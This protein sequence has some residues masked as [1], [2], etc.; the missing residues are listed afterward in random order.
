MHCG[1]D[2]MCRGGCSCRWKT[3]NLICKVDKKSGEKKDCKVD[4]STRDYDGCIDYSDQMLT[5]PPDTTRK[6][7]VFSAFL[8]HPR[9]CN[10]RRSI[11]S[12]LY[13]AKHPALHNSAK[14]DKTQQGQH[15]EPSERVFLGESARDPP[16]STDSSRAPRA[17]MV[18]SMQF[19]V[20]EG[21]VR[22][23][24]QIGPRPALGC[25][26][27]SLPV[28]VSD[29]L[30]IGGSDQNRQ[31]HTTVLNRLNRLS[32]TVESVIGPHSLRLRLAGH[33]ACERRLAAS[34]DSPECSEAEH[35]EAWND[36]SVEQVIV[37]DSCSSSA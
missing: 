5:L 18:L 1:D 36:E 29:E 28:K 21:S 24:E 15:D 25:R 19:P 9:S 30:R 11:L 20:G 6:F 14:A 33:V 34:R 8:H 16:A 32:M 7:K 10:Y 31:S 2:T 27:M 26:M 12:F 17:K 13:A 35:L 4:N 37:E 22:G 3:G 23:T